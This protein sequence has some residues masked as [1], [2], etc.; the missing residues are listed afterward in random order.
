M[1]AHRYA[2]CY[3]LSNLPAQSIIVNQT[4]L[5]VDDSM[6]IRHTVCR[7]LEEQ[8]FAVESATNGAEALEMLKSMEQPA[9]IITDLQMPRLDGHQLIDAL[10]DQPAT[11]RIPIV[12][13][14]ARQSRAEGVPEK[15][16]DYVIFKDI[17]ILAQLQRAIEAVVVRAMS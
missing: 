11:A 1:L 2:V 12:V 9:V 14:A 5:V 15:R 13:L 6:L 7:Y 16:A 4:V 8:G 10:K 17:E 3:F